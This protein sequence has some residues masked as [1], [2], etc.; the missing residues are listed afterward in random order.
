M[1]NI[2]TAL[3][4]HFQV[5]LNNIPQVR[6]DIKFSAR[7]TAERFQPGQAFVEFV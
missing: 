5:T 2:N 4:A 3:S 1:A 7:S 6:I